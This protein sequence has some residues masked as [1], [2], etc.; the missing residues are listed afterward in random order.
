MDKTVKMQENEMHTNT[1]QSEPIEYTNTPQRAFMPKITSQ[2][3]Q[4]ST[5]PLP[6]KSIEQQM[7]IEYNRTPSLTN[8][9]K[10]AVEQ[11]KRLHIEF[12][13][14][15]PLIYSRPT[16]MHIDHNNLQQQDQFE[17]SHQPRSEQQMEL[18]YNISTPN[19][20]PALP[21]LPAPPTLPSLPAPPTLP[22]LPAPSTLPSLPAPPTLPSLPAPPASLSLTQIPT[23]L[24]D[25]STNEE[26]DDCENTVEYEKKLPIT[27]ETNDSK[28]LIPYDSKALIPYEDYITIGA[29]PKVNMKTVFYTCKLYETK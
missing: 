17:I 15:L 29:R 8:E 24:R 12:A 25:S 14:P 11:E 5:T 13:P 19:A 22:S 1:A 20:I 7:E 9:I 4:P 27:H 2:L 21:S 26:C 28:V 18:D 16:K 10:K 3:S 6:Q 23:S